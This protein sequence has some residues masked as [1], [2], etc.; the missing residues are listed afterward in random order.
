VSR[1]ISNPPVAEDLM[2]TARSFGNYDLALSLADL[3]D[4]S[5]TANATEIKI[6]MDFNDRDP[7]ISVS[8]NGRG[9]SNSQLFVAMRLASQNPNT[10]KDAND[11][12]RFGL[13]L[14]TA[15]FAQASCL[16]V[17]SYDGKN[18]A[19]ARWD[20][21]NVAD[22]GME[23][24][25]AEEVKSLFFDKDFS[26]SKTEV[27]WTKLNRLTEN[28][29]ISERQ[30]NELMIEAIDEISLVF[31]R[32][33]AGEVKGRKKLNIVVN[34]NELEPLDPF[35][36]HHPACQELQTENIP[37]NGARIQITPYILPHFSK[38]KP[39]EYD[40]LA[41]R[42]GHVKNQGFYVY[43]NYRLIIKGTW[44]KLVPHG[45]LSKLARV[46][47]DIPN[48]LDSEWKISVDKS[49]VQIPTALKKR[50]RDLLSR[51]TFSSNKVFTT[52]G[53]NVI[54]TKITQIWDQLLNKGKMSFAINQTHPI[55]DGFLSGLDKSTRQQFIGVLRILQEGLP[56]A[57]MHVAMNDRPDQ[58]VQS[59][60]GPEELLPIVALHVQNRLSS[61]VSQ[62]EILASLEITAPFSEYFSQIVAYL[63]FEGIIDASSNQY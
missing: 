48:S 36:T 1:I 24:F 53:K 44:F 37:I 17:V 11:L 16:T 45:E 6:S 61:G 58:I 33:L 29:T 46:R 41:G 49:E 4:N 18:Y 7:V 55:I 52:K 51:I 32:Y 26:A 10:K 15:S 30:F 25:D 23:V 20:L 60:T 2:E 59:A 27:T 34:E 50:L 22:W 57:A 8:D 3:I 62:N 40:K 21:E 56:L 35:Y 28:G 63:K 38:L 13:G 9:M 19:G 43:R 5:I 12:G 54:D 42:E 14:K 39:N 47:V 31:H